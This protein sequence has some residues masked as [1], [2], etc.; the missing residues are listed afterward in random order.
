[1][2]GKAKDPNP[3]D[4]RQDADVA[5]TRCGAR[6]ARLIAQPDIAL[7]PAC[8]RIEVARISGDA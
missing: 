5:C 2:D 7:C 1:M 6:P 4:L 8:E 3:R